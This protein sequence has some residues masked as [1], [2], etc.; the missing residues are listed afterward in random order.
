MRT[1]RKERKLERI[2]SNA[3]ADGQLLDVTDH[4]RSCRLDVPV[5]LS[6]SLWTC[7][8]HPFPGALP[9]DYLPLDLLLVDLVEYLQGKG[10][11]LEWVGHFVPNNRPDWLCRSFMLRVRC[12]FLG[13]QL[14]SVILCCENELFTQPNAKSR[15]TLPGTLLVRM[16]R[17]LRRLDH[18]CRTAEAGL[19]SKLTRELRLLVSLS[20]FAAYTD[21][22]DVRRKPRLPEG[23]SVEE[24]RAVLVD[25]LEE[26]LM[27]AWG[28]STKETD[29]P[30][31]KMIRLRQAL[32]TPL[33]ELTWI[34]ERLLRITGQM[35]FGGQP[36]HTPFRQFLAAY[37]RMTAA[38]DEGATVVPGVVVQTV[39]DYLEAIENFV[40]EAHQNEYRRLRA[41]FGQIDTGEPLGE[42]VDL[43][44]K[45]AQH[46]LVQ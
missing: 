9:G 7:L 44:A 46:T 4:A 31:W 37:H 10:E 22:W 20:P 39:R 17:V 25:S 6:S 42:W 38:L 28:C 33:S 40:P 23:F 16:N 11:S 24:Y 5:A 32:E 2:Y 35:T 21:T 18:A 36:V 15:S 41:E 26:L 8:V 45:E 30:V 3:L 34:T 43:K 12:N 19:L 14:S 29:V 1:T 13:G 27:T